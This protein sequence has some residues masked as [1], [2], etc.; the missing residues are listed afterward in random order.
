M[1]EYKEELLVRWAYGEEVVFEL[2]AALA[3]LLNQGILI[4]NN[5]W[6]RKDFSDY[7]KQLFSIS[8]NCSD[9]FCFASADA[10]EMMF[11]D[12]QDVF[13]HWEKDNKWGTT[14]WCI[15]KRKQEPIGPVF[16]AII[17]DGIWTEKDIKFFGG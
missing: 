9:V 7:Q 3:V 14:V 13:E 2:E 15:K 12:I 16:D 10:E 4:L 8:V 5:H 11:K 6:W 17:N 1:D